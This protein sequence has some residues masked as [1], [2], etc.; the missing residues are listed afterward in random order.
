MDTAIAYEKVRRIIDEMNLDAILITDRYNMRYIASYRGEGIIVLAGSGKTVIT[1][2]RYTEQVQRECEGYECADIAGKGYVACI[3]SILDGQRKNSGNLRVGFENL[4]ISY[5]EYSEY[6]T[7]ISG[8]EWISLDGKLDSLREIKTDEEIENIHTAESI[9]DKAFS[10]ILEYLRPGI[11]EKDV[12]L[13]LEYHMKKM[14]R[15]A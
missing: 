4:S 7:G 3:S 9:G 8:V 14:V 5:R 6:S 1:D 12:A 2:S 10:H 15:K 11:T 13:E